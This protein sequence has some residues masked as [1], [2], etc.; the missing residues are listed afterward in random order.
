[1][2]NNYNAPGDHRDGGRERDRQGLRND[3]PIADREVPLGLSRTPAAIHEWLDGDASEASVR[4]GDMARHVDFWKRLDAEA[5]VRRQMR[6][7]AHVM[8]A[9]MAAIPAE[10]PAMVTPWYRRRVELSPMAFAAIGAGLVAA[11]LALGAI[12]R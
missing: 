12:A 11:G 6:T 1:M 10:R 3:Q 4:R 5:N 2:S 7:P 9:I 8:D